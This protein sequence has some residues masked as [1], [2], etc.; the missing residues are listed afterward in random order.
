M[1]V[2]ISEVRTYEKKTAF[3]T[4]KKKDENLYEGYTEVDIEGVKGVS[5]LTER[6]ISVNG[7]TVDK[8]V[9]KERVKEQPVTRVIRVGTKER[10]PTVGSGTYIWP[11]NG[12]CV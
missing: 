1:T 6:T 12:R 7:E 2:K 5:Q 10:P 3:E 8:E 11:T 9:L 4:K